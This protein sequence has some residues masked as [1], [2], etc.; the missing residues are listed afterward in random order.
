MEAGE[1]QLE[2]ARI[3]VDVA[4]G[5][6]TRNIGLEGGSVGRDEFVVHLDTPVSPP[7][8]I[9]RRLPRKASILRTA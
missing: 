4:D 6:K 2:F 9:S 8:T 1:D 3:G 7:P 5:E